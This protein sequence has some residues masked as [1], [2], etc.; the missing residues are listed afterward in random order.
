[1]DAFKRAKALHKRKIADLRTS[2][3][4][5]IIDELVSDGKSYSL[6]CK[7]NGLFQQLNSFAVER[8]LISKNY[9]E[10]VKLPK[11]PE[12][13]QR[14]LS[15]EEQAAIWSV[16]NVPGPYQE[17][18]RI[19]VVLFCT[20]MRIGELLSMKS[21][22]VHLSEGYAIGGEKTSAG[23][24]RVIPLPPPI[25]EI[26]ADW[27]SNGAPT[28]VCT[29]TGT[30][31]DDSH[32]R[33]RF[34]DLMKELN[35]TGVTPHTCR[36]TAATMMAAAGVAPKAIQTILGHASYSTTA[37]IYTHPQIKE[38]ISAANSVNWNGTGMAQ[39]EKTIKIPGA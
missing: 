26:I 4:Q 31:R 39:N 34:G 36:H 12:P 35:I 20:G 27:L 9:A 23:R 17:T 29:K 33:H 24:R 11:K 19:A 2:D 21:E 13:K 1:M 16:A 38:L 8:D 30:P 22:D 5:L 6:C 3:Y 10:F 15:A 25:Q 14:I 7:Q 37:T 18:A 32:V 28:L